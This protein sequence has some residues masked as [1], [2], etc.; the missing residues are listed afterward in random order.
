MTRPLRPPARDYTEPFR[1]AFSRSAVDWLLVLLLVA[2]QMAIQTIYLRPPF[3]SDQM[4]YFTGALELPSAD[5]NHWTLRIGLLFLIRLAQEAFGYA[6]AAYYFVPYLSGAGLVAATYW[7]GRLLFGRAV[8]AASAVIVFVNPY[9]LRESSELLPDIPAAAAFAGAATLLISTGQRHKKTGQLTPRDRMFMV[10]AGILVGLSYLIRDVIA[11]FLFPVVPII[12][13]VFRLPLRNLPHVALPALGMFGVEILWGALVYSDPLVHLRI[14]LARRNPEEVLRAR[15]SMRAQPGFFTQ[16]LLVLPR[17]FLQWATGELFLGLA[18]LLLAATVI[19]RDRR[20]GILAVWALVVWISLTALGLIGD[21]GGRAGLRITK[22]RYWFPIFPPLVVGGVAGAW[23]LVGRLL[24]GSRLRA[25]TASAV[26]MVLT[27]SIAL[28]TADQ[29]GRWSIFVRSGSGHFSELR[30]WLAS[31]DG[32]NGQI[33]RTDHLT[34]QV[35]P[36]YTRTTFGSPVWSGTVEPF[37]E[38]LEDDRHLDNPLCFAETARGAGE[39]GI[40]VLHSQSVRSMLP[41]CG[42]RPALDLLGPP[43][44]RVPLMVTS[45]A[46]VIVYGGSDEAQVTDLYAGEGGS[47]TPGWMAAS[48]EGRFTPVGT[49]EIALA[50]G[51]ELVILDGRGP[52]RRAPPQGGPGVER[53][54][55]VWVRLQISAV[56]R[57]PVSF[58]CYFYS[59]GGKRRAVPGASGFLPSAEAQW[60]EFVCRP[61]PAQGLLGVRVGLKALGPGKL[62]VGEFQVFLI[63][64]AGAATAAS[65]PSSNR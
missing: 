4:V 7:L 10:S 2:G 49:G 58:F 36:M 42:F 35:L 43:G 62:S 64:A 13:L 22:A 18:G 61:P 6:E 54:D 5:P 44:G 9:V 32:G 21:P 12:F 50:Q 29:V 34:A 48:P 25:A 26:V 47:E 38:V 57:Q 28:A 56:T 20:V 33:L 63:K 23:L 59:A 8:G 19:M 41:E 3:V 46:Q 51:E 60:G 31:S 65:S 16:T 15:A 40:V 24:S 14:I 11:V 53:T 17:I 52:G 45:N 30:S 1:A 39:A 55:L 37:R 27:L